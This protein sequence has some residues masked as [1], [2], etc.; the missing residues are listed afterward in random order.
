MTKTN[1]FKSL[2]MILLFAFGFANAWGQSEVTWNFTNASPSSG[3]PITNLTISDVTRGNNNPEPGTNP[4]L[5]NGSVSTYS[6]A[7][8]GN[9][10]GVAARIGTLDTA[11][12]GY[13]QFTLTPAS[14]N[15]VTLSEIR[16]GARST[17]TGPAAYA[18][19]SSL[20]NYTSNIATGSINPNS[21][22]AVKSNLSLS[23]TSLDGTAITYRI[24]GYNGSGSAGANTTNWRIDD[25]KITVTTTST[26]PCD[27]GTLTGGNTVATLT[28]VTSGG[29]TV[30]S[31]SGASA[32]SGLSYQ[33]QNSTDGSSWSDISG[34]TASSYTATNITE[35]VYY[36]AKVQCGDTIVESTPVLVKIAY[37]TPNPLPS[38]DFEYISNVTVGTD[39]NNTSGRSD[40]IF[41]PTPVAN[42]T[43]GEP[44]SISVEIAESYTSDNVYLFIDWNQ[45]R[46]LNDA[47][48]MIPLTYT[49]TSGT[50]TATGIIT[51]PAEAVL[52]NT[53][54]R[55][56]LIDG[57]NSTPCTTYSWGEI[58]D[59]TV[60][61]STS[62]II[63][64]TANEWSNG[65]GPLST[66]DDVLIEGDLVISDDLLAGNLT[67]SETGSVTVTEGG[68]L[69]LG[70]QIINN[71]TAS[72]FVVAHG[73]N[74]IQTSAFTGSNTGDITVE[75]NSRPMYRTDMTLWSSPVAGQAIKA[76]SPTTLDNRFWTYDEA[77]LT[78]SVLPDVNALFE[79]GE[80]I[81]IRIG[82][83][84]NFGATETRVHEGKF[85][86]VPHNGDVTIPVVNTTSGFNLIGNPYASTINADAFLSANQSIE[87]LYFW[88]HENPVGSAN[89]DNN[90]AVF[91]DAG[92]TFGDLENIASAQ[93]FIIN[94]NASTDVV[95][96]NDMRNAENAYFYKNSETERNRIWLSL[97][98]ADHKI[99]QILVAYMTGATNDFD[100]QIDAK[101]LGGTS[102]AF[103]NLLDNDKYAIQ[104]RTLPFEA[105]DV[106]PLGFKV[107]ES[108]SYTINLENFDGLFTTGDV[109]VLIKDNKT[110][111][112][113][114][115][116][117]SAYVFEAEQGESN[118]RFEIVYE[119]ESIL[120]T[121]DL[122][123]NSVQVYTT[124]QNIVVDSKN[125]KILSVALYDLSGRNIHRNDKVNS[126]VY[127]IAKS[128]LAKQ[129]LVVKV[130]TANGDIIT[131]KIINQ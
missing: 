66:D 84:A 64:T 71:A 20:D 88:T 115:L 106:V 68:S 90:Y 123:A 124:T 129:V 118:D 12:S 10:A 27:E 99:G 70:G 14:G 15:T 33:W 104:G 36:R 48:E 3:T 6:G 42:L 111:T 24:Y 1:H 73:A 128:P 89:Y 44:T 69:T 43:I 57:N 110:N 2:L 100:H 126:N 19:R 47:N 11:T 72:D 77:N 60:N 7:S 75:R 76:F 97:S 58:E 49:A 121:D 54:M 101:I 23:S 95:F 87:A 127:Q 93:G 130:K 38:S 83:D 67:V 117:E 74:L 112:I 13:F 17:G 103:Y 98:N 32:G 4:L 82:Y 8:G 59:Y 37:C 113:H 63:W 45:D 41:Y 105:S 39:I 92:G 80:G 61:V 116:S 21:T 122:T 96:N 85:I 26:A 5:N 119:T 131:K 16:F 108:G 65:T 91:S 22:W 34:A 107:A 53:R 120:G 56:K 86:G 55:V 102:E 79:A 81:A 62:S 31:L 30:L 46:D 40:Y 52:G 114:D 29:S 28:E 9:N 25:L 109:K 125:H 18:L 51:P 50:F 78:Y 35:D 94:T